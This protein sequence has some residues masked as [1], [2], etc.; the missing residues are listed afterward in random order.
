[1]VNVV[2]LQSFNWP[3]IHF[4]VLILFLRRL[5]PIQRPIAIV[6]DLFPTLRRLVAVRLGGVGVGILVDGGRE[7]EDGQDQAEHNTDQHLGQR[8]VQPGHGRDWS[9]QLLMVGM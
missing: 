9:R 5:V 4:I 3:V 7:Q 6:G 2:E 8:T 1:M